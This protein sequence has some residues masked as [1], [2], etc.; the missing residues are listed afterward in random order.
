LLLLLLL[1]LLSSTTRP[2]HNSMSSEV[3]GAD[4]SVKQNDFA[5]DSVL[6]NKYEPCPHLYFAG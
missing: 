5:F 2:L 1:L 3:F 6:T 4:V